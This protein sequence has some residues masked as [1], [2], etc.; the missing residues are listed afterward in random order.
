MRTRGLLKATTRS[1]LTGYRP[2]HSPSEVLQ[3]TLEALASAYPESQRPRALI[4]FA[5]AIQ[6]PDETLKELEKLLA[7]D[8]GRGQ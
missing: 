1:P 7:G 5:K 4:D 3:G 2:V 8:A 6:L